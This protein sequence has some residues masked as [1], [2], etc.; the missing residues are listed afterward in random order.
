MGLRVRMLAV[1]RLL[2]V[3]RVIHHQELKDVEEGVDEGVAQA[4]RSRRITQAE[5]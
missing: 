4:A 5:D 3:L 2:L 1:R